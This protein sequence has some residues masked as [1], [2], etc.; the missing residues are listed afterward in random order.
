MHLR[1]KM[2]NKIHNS[3]RERARFTLLKYSLFAKQFLITEN[4]QILT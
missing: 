1:L 4:L 3:V 2:T